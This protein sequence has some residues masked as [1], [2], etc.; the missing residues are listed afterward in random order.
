VEPRANLS[1]EVSALFGSKVTGELKITVLGGN[2]SIKVRAG[3]EG[4]KVNVD[5]NEAETVAFACSTVAVVVVK[6]AG[7]VLDELVKGP[8]L[9]VYEIVK[10]G[11]VFVKI[12]E[13][14]LIEECTVHHIKEVGGNIT[15]CKV[16][17]VVD[18]SLGNKGLGPPGLFKLN[19]LILGEVLSKSLGHKGCAGHGVARENIVSVCAG[20][21][22]VGAGADKCSLVVVVTGSAGELESDTELILN[23]LVSVVD[24]VVYRFAVGVFNEELGMLNVL[25]IKELDGFAVKL[26]IIGNVGR[27]KKS[28]FCGVVA[29]LIAGRSSSAC[30]A[31]GIFRV[32]SVSTGYGSGKK[33]NYC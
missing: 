20:L 5:G 4:V 19:D 3:E 12:N 2:Y 33:H 24:S 32:V 26:E 17:S 14:I 16:D 15:G 31:L 13:H 18:G 11:G 25:P 1:Y 10:G 22:A 21:S 29:S 30:S 7:G 28:F 8:L 23:A 6:Y 27:C 9:I